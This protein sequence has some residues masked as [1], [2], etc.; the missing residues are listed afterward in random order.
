[1]HALAGSY[2][3]HE[4]NLQS[5]MLIISALVFVLCGCERSWEVRLLVF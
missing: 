4:F 3:Y 5:G 1:M 2:R